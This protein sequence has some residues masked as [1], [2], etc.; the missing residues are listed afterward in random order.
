[1]V[2]SRTLRMGYA[3]GNKSMRLDR[4]RVPALSIF[5]C[6]SRGSKVPAEALEIDEQK[7]TAFLIKNLFEP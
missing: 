5:I 7:V 4:S 6:S 3:I 2:T 1:M